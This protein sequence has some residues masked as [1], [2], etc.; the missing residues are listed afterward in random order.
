MNNKNEQDTREL[1]DEQEEQ[2]KPEA[3]RRD[4]LRT[5]SMGLAGLAGAAALGVQPSKVNAQTSGSDKRRVVI[6]ADTNTHMMPALAREMASRNHDLVLGDAKDGLA[7]ELTQA[8]AR[9]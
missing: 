6:L 3:S 8:W 9:R 1:A 7:D 2:V 5:G 4:F